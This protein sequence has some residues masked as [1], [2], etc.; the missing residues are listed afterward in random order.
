MRG[1]WMPL[2]CGC[3]YIL[4]ACGRAT[5]VAAPVGPVDMGA[6]VATGEG[7][8]GARVAWV[9]DAPAAAVGELLSLQ[10][11]VSGIQA[12]YGF[13]LQLSYDPAMLEVVD[14]DAGTE[15]DQIA[16]GGFLSPDFVVENRADADVGTISYAVTQSA[17]A[18]ARS[19]EGPL[20]VVEL[21]A[22]AAGTATLTI[23]ELLLSDVDG[24][25]LE[26]DWEDLAFT[27]H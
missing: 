5:P 22:S 13:E 1:L 2:L 21:R 4:G 6:A 9:P 17:P 7:E 19:G 24:A 27:I 18:E 16:H 8:S 15:G 23:R 3:L 10:L 11:R 20:V 25:A 12:L 14:V 26:A